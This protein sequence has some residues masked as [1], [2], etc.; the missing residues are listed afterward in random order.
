[1]MHHWDQGWGAG[2]W[3][4][5]GFGMVVFWALLVAVIVWLVRSTG[6]RPRVVSTARDILD[7]R[8]ARGEITDEEYRARRTTLLGP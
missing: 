3:L 2:N 8:Y 4:L 5:M 6:T 7:E 1:M